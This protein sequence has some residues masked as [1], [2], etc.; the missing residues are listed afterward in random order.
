MSA[1]KLSKIENG[2]I[3]PNLVDVELVLTALDFQAVSVKNSLSTPVASNPP[4][5]PAA[6]PAART[7]SR[8]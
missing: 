7:A 6:R 3:L 4:M 1:G 5:G 8:K 2:R